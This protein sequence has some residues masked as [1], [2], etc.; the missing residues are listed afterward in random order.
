MKI[1]ILKGVKLFGKAPH[2]DK[3]VIASRRSGDIVEC[4]RQDANLAISSGRAEEIVEGIEPDT[5]DEPKRKAP[6][7][8][9][10]T[11]KK[12]ARKAPRKKSA[13]ARTGLVKED[14]DA[15]DDAIVP[16]E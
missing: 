1:R 9:N 8:R 2:D 16:N 13:A 5:P 4:R 10:P 6:K 12:V 14:P 15:D 11:P 7:R 3:P